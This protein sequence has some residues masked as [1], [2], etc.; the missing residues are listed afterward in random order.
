MQ[1]ALEQLA[2]QPVIAVPLA[3]IVERHHQQVALLDG[4]ELVRRAGGVERRVAHRAAEAVE[5]RRA[6]QERGALRRQLVED[7]RAEVVPKEP[8][9]TADRHARVATS[10]SDLHRQRGEVQPRRPALRTLEQLLH[11][12]VADV[13]PRAGEQTGRLVEIECEVL[14]L[15]LEQPTLEAEPSLGQPGLHPRRQDQ[16][17]LVGQPGRQ[18]LE[19]ARAR[20]VGHA[21]EVVDDHRHRHRDRLEH[22][23]HL[24]RQRRRRQAGGERAEHARPH[25]LD[26]VDG[27]CQVRAERHGVVVGLVGRQPCDGRREL[28]DPARQQRRLAVAGRRDDGRDRRVGPAQ[29]I[30]QDGAAHDADAR[31]DRPELRLA[32]PERRWL[33]GSSHGRD[34]AGVGHPNGGN[35]GGLGPVSRG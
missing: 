13:D 4:F 7:L 18:L 3:S 1:L 17:D 33:S 11:V 22:V 16:T 25:R 30:E 8:T 26:P 2:E 35:H 19:E 28:V 32:E 6:D 29:P 34:I 10:G 21:L 27:R 14:R 24:R 31:D 23:E 9:V 15:D 12:E 20:G 5:D